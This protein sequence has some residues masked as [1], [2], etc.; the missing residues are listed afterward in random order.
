MK[1]SLRILITLL[2]L[3]VAT[4]AALVY[5]VSL[6]Q[7][8]RDSE[9][10]L[11]LELA[12]ERQKSDQSTQLKRTLAAAEK[13]HTEMS[14]FFVD[15]SDE[16]Q[17]SFVSQIERLGTQSSGIK[18]ETKSID[19][20]TDVPHSLHGIFS[21]EGSWSGVYHFIRL[22]E[23]YPSH[24]VITRLDLHGSPLSDNWTGEVSISVNSLKSLPQ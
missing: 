6:M 15:P 20:S 2:F 5:C 17:I 8:K 13:E 10:Q 14:K 16:G 21:V 18:I 22:L 9:T 4:I 7:A 1:R 11:Q 24:L 12:A 23:V 19:L 3:N